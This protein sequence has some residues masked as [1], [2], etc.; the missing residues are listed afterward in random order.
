MQVSWCGWAREAVELAELR[1]LSLIQNACSCDWPI[2][3]IDPH[4][5]RLG[6]SGENFL[7]YSLMLFFNRVDLRHSRGIQI[8]TPGSLRGIVCRHQRNGTSCRAATLKNHF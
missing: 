5:E 8:R 6:K 7:C 3:K 1:N 4:S 2:I